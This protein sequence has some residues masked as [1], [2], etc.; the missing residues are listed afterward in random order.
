MGETLVDHGTGRSRSRNS[1]IDH[2][3]DLFG[4]W[5]AGG[6]VG[7]DDSSPL[8]IL[9]PSA[10]GSN[11]TSLVLCATQTPPLHSGDL[12]HAVL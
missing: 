3:T 6:T 5:I 7:K 11:R 2:E 9:T 10:K 12:H 4:I 1:R 8:G